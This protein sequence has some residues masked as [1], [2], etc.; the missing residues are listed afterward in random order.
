MHEVARLGLEE[1]CLVQSR[2]FER[3]WERDSRAV[4]SY[5]VS[6]V[7]RTIQELYGTDEPALGVVPPQ[8]VVD[9]GSTLALDD[10]FRPVIEPE[11][12]FVATRPLSAAAGV[13]EILDAC[14]V[15]PGFE[16]PDSRYAGWYPLPDGTVAD[17]VA[18]GAFAEQGR[19][20]QAGSHI[21]SGTFA[22]PVVVR[23]GTFRADYEGIGSVEVSFA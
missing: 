14:L 1:A 7:T 15:A 17:L 18:D 6:L 23:A 2:V 21:A 11:L 12:V 3:L 8:H 10:L 16:V 5:K 9:S 19:I 4:P 13:E 20:V 22:D